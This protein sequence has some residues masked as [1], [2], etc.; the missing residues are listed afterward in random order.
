MKK[1]L[2]A[3]LFAVALVVPAVAENM[4]IGGSFGFN[5][6]SPKDGDSLSNYYIAPEFGYSL[7]EK[8]DIGIDLEYRY[9]EDSAVFDNG[10]D[11]VINYVEKTTTLGIAPFVRYKM[12][13]I[14]SVDF[15]AK[16]SIFY[17]KSKLDKADV[18]Y[19]SY[20]LRVVPI[21]S[22][23][24]NETWSIGA[25]LDFASIVFENTKDDGDYENTYFGL[26]ANN[27]DLFSI[28]FSY[29]F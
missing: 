18:E 2:L 23:S 28:G 4:W 1:S 20:G 7:D 6:S 9:G 10:V 5:N 29:H 12:F 27:G 25:T 3:V 24:I 17:E 26:D 11:P 16:G 21:V 13:S 22:Y 19:T 14:A 8:M 15:L